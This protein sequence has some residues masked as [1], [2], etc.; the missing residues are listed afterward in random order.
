MPGLAL[1]FA[2]VGGGGVLVNTVVLFVLYHWVGLPLLS[3]SAIA[4]ELA[5]VHNYLLNDRWTFAVGTPSLRR[6]IK[7]NISVLGGLGVNVLIVWSLVRGERICCWRIASASR[8]LS[9]S[10]SR[11]VPDGSGGGGADDC[12]HHLPGADRGLDSAHRAVGPRPLPHALHLGP[13]GCRTEG[14]GAG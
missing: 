9:R 7:F 13:G 14:Q 11:R 6:F 4:V 2:V 12:R 8:R 1:R 5:V 3:A 10:T